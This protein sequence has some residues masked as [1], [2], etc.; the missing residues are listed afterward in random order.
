MRY[1]LPGIIG[2]GL[3]FWKWYSS[4]S[5]SDSTSDTSSIEYD[6]VL[7]EIYNNQHEITKFNNLFGS[8]TYLPCKCG[9]PR[10]VCN[11][12][13]SLSNT[14]FPANVILF[15]ISN[16]FESPASGIPFCFNTPL[17]VHSIDEILLQLDMFVPIQYGTVMIHYPTT[18]GTQG[19]QG[20]ELL[21]CA[22]TSTEAKNIF[23]IRELLSRI[24]QI[25]EC[26]ESLGY[27]RKPISNI[28]IHD[29][30]VYLM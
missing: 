19:T 27:Y 16:E 7:S 17:T 25:V 21:W 26:S 3:L 22:N 11:S 12:C 4:R 10:Q 14:N 9:F 30:D 8:D 13:N 18:Q 1:L 15:S 20:T 2:G 5:S 24:I 28:V 6:T 29:I 23:P